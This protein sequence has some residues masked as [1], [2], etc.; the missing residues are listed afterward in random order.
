MSTIYTTHQL[1]QLE[2]PTRIAQLLGLSEAT[3]RRY[4][5]DGKIPA[6]KVGPKLWRVKTRELEPM[7]GKRG[8]AV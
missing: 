3:V 1:G 8:L 4:C 6:V 5:R 7:L 2:S